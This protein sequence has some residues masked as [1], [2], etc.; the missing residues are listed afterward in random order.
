MSLLFWED[1]ESD[2]RAAILGLASRSIIEIFRVT[3]SI[4]AKL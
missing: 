2:V 4:H 1:T 3:R